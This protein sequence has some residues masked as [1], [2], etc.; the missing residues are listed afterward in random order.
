MNQ[1]V[2]VLAQC[3][4]TVT[5][6]FTLEQHLKSVIVVNEFRRIRP[7]RGRVGGQGVELPLIVR[8][9]GIPLH[10]RVLIRASLDSEHPGNER[11]GSKVFG[12]LDWP[13]HTIDAV[14][15]LSI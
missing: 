8:E 10:N 11:L 1:G 4:R 3:C 7:Q 6:D 9:R 14:Q 2:P 13:Q 15:N 12:H 5:R